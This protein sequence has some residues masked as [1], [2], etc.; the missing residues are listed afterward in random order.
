MIILGTLFAI[1]NF[2]ILERV[3]KT[4]SRAMEGFIYGDETLIEKVER[5]AHEPALEPGSVV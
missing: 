2:W 1:Y 3:K 4:H 5:K